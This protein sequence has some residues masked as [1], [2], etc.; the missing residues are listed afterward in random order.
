MVKHQ[1]LR[2]KLDREINFDSI[3]MQ[4]IHYTE[5]DSVTKNSTNRFIWAY[6]NK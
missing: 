3:K 4:I 2:L 5:T 6:K 1:I